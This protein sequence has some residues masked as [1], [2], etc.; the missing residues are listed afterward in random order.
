MTDIS[1]EKLSESN[2]DDVK[3]IFDLSF[4]HPWSI[5]AL[6]KE[7]TNSNAYYTVLKL[8]ANVV[9][10][11][12]IWVIFDEATVINIAVHPNFRGH[13]F[14]DIILDNLI[15]NSKLMGASCMT[16]EVRVSNKSAISLYEKHGFKI[17]GTRKNFYSDPTE[18]GHIMWNYSI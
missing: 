6:K 10:F 4:S 9:G 3:S 11:G 8:G 18:D 14:G 15:D 16:L 17:E 7:M 2:I 12:G 5:D 1:F 13:G